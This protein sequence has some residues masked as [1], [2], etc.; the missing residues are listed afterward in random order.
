M[1]IVYIVFTLFVLLALF[2]LKKAV[3]LYA[4]WKLFFNFNV[5][6]GSFTFDFAISLVFIIIF[7]FKRKT[8]CNKN[9]PFYKSF[10]VYGI[11]YSLTCLIP[12]VV[13]S[14]IP[15]IIVM[16]L[17][18]SYIYYF[19]LKSVKDV[20]FAVI[21][22]ALF[23]IILC[24]NGLLAPLFGINPLDDYLQSI[25]F[26][27]ESIFIDNE[28]LRM[29][30]VR[31]R[32]FIPHAISYGVACI[33]I[34]Y[35]LVW[36]YLNVILSKDREYG[37]VMLISIL[38][39]FSGVI[40]SGSRTPILGLLP[41]VFLFFYLKYIPNQATRVICIGFLLSLF[42]FGEYIIYSIQSL[43]ENKI[44]EDA[45][46]SSTDLR[47]EQYEIAWQWMKEDFIFGKGMDFDAFRANSSILGAESVWL[48][49]MFNNG[50]VGVISYI[51]FY[52]YII[53][54][55]PHNKICRIYLSIIII[56]WL[57]MR[58]ATSLIGVSDAQF[59]T[60]FFCIYKYYQLQD[61]NNETIICYP[62][63]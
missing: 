56:G 36:Y 20:K 4:P 21:S 25:S 28:W 39:L 9:F 32:S 51:L 12:H 53:K 2:D 40:I 14:F 16:V 8:L 1:S 60:V 59:L 46:G 43:L 61:E 29:G 47:F 49:L 58:T 15:R 17:G 18:F 31:Y 34:L 52:Y 55:F 19:C 44:A 7:L 33:I 35:L 22:Y 30:N 62:C 42:A 54:K 23:A 37:I 63:L 6:F 48:P 5:R 26:E 38:L 50:I 27:D 13:I 3:L 10:V 45:G 24:A 57:L 41:L 11:L